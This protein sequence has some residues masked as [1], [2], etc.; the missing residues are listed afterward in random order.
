MRLY[1]KNYTPLGTARNLKH[2]TRDRLYVFMLRD[3]Q[4]QYGSL[5]SVGE[6]AVVLVTGSELGVL[7]KRSQIARVSDDLTSPAR[8]AVFSARSSWLDVKAAAPK[9][10]GYLHIVT[11]GRDEWKWKHPEVSDDGITFD[12]ITVGKAN[13]RYVFY[14]RSKPLTVYEEYLHEED[15]RWLA[16]IPL[17]GNLLPGKIN[18]LLYNSDLAEDNSPM[19]CR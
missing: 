19:A 4:C 7:I 8:D 13:V 3:G 12:G 15:F 2:V 1:E 17:L 9:E 14:V 11:K 6:Q 18:V 5:S 10:T 16:S